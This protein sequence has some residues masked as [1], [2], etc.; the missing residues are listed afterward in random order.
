M[1]VGDHHVHQAMRRE[2]VFP[3]EGLVDALR[4]ALVVKQQILRP[5]RKAQMRPVERPAGAAI[6]MRRRVR[7]HRLG[8]RRLEAE[9]AGHL[10]AAQKDLQNVQRAAGLE[11]VGMG[12]DAAHG[13]KADRAARSSFRAARPGN[14]SRAGRSRSPR[15]RRRGQGP[16]RYGGC[17]SPGCR[18][19]RPPPRARSRPT[20]S[21]RPKLEGGAVRDPALRHVPAR[22]GCTAGSS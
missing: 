18:S 5:A 19:V 3:C 4:P 11:A 8:V 7:L 1:R 2:R 15:Q 22:S 9:A 21:V 14:R 12:A 6:A 17:V 10:D 20:G 13:V 16:R